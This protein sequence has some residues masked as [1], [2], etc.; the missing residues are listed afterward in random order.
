MG[1][2]LGKSLNRLREVVARMFN[3][4]FRRVPSHW[5]K[6]LEYPHQLERARELTSFSASGQA[7]RAA[8]TIVLGSGYQHYQLY[9]H[10]MLVWFRQLAC[11]HLTDAVLPPW[12]AP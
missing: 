6:V 9:G 11:E 3:V 5:N 12:G 8:Q 4:G 2:A 1:R 7:D 10:S